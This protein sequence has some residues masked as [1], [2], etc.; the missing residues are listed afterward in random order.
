MSPAAPIPADPASPEPAA[1]EPA[2]TERAGAEKA[3][4]K[5][6]RHYLTYVL[7]G[8][9]IGGIW[10]WHAG[11]SPLQHAA[12]LIVLLVIVRLAM[13][14]RTTIRAKR[15]KPA[16]EPPVSLARFVVAKLALVAVGV[17][18]SLLLGLW[19]ADPDY[20]TAVLLFVVT[21]LVGPRI[22]PWLSAGPGT[23]QG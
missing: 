17:C 15:G 21:A 9:A 16:T 19:L 2:G 3:G 14:V 7:A 8:A 18:A 1:P 6:E 13:M 5:H 10:A 20:V 4:G 22:H 23:A 12:R 11:E